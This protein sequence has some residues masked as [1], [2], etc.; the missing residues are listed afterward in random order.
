MRPNKALCPPEV[1]ETIERY[2]T[3][4]AQPGDFVRAVLE[5]RLVDSFSRA[6]ENNIE[7]MPH[8][9]AYLYDE[10]PM[11]ARGVENVSAWL[12]RDWTA[13][14]AATAVTQTT[15]EEVP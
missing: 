15:G 12:S 5:D 6:D 10:V 11:I 2:L 13:A 9:A 3:I 4:G 8:I 14:R 1:R 7:A